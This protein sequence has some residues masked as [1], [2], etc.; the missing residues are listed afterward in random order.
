MKG[1]GRVKGRPGLFFPEF[2][3]VVLQVSA[4]QRGAGVNV[5]CKPPEGLGVDAGDER[6][7]LVKDDAYVLVLE[8]P[9]IVRGA[10]SRARG[11]PAIH[12]SIS[13]MMGFGHDPTG[14]IR[15]PGRARC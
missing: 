12:S 13:D 7:I 1:R 8:V 9:I 3:G 14:S 5:G 4:R 15:F 6:R 2:P 11:Q 10:L